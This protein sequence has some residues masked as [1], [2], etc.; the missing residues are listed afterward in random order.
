VLQQFRINVDRLGNCKP[1]HMTVS[2]IKSSAVGTAS[3]RVV[4][5]SSE[6]WTEKR[7]LES[8]RQRFG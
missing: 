8:I 4:L 5:G 7:L 6:M 1:G 2:T 3:E